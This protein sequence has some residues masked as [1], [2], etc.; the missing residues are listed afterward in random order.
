VQS[1]GGRASTAGEPIH[2]RRPLKRRDA[3]LEHGL[4]GARAL[5]GRLP[6]RRGETPLSLTRGDDHPQ[7]VP[8]GG[9][10]SDLLIIP[11]VPFIQRIERVAA[12]ERGFTT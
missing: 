3:R 10:P 6:L 9:V 2:W 8:A 11:P 4:E 5:A 1:L 12:F 7:K